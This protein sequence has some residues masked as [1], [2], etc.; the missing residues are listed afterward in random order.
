MYLSFEFVFLTGTLQKGKSMKSIIYLALTLISLLSMPLQ[1]YESKTNPK[2]E[3]HVI[4]KVLETVNAAGYTYLK[5]EGADKKQFW[6]A[7]QEAE[8]K[9]G[10][11]VQADTNNLMEN[12]QSKTLNRTFDKIYFAMD[13]KKGKT[14]ESLSTI[15]TKT[16]EYSPQGKKEAVAIK[17]IEKL[18]D[19]KSIEEIFSGKNELK[20]KIVKLRGQVVKYNS[21]IMGKNW[22][23]LQDGS[24]KTGENDLVITSDDEVSLGDIIEVQGKVILDKDFGAGY[25]YEVILEEG[26]VL[27]K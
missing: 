14:A 12:F 6:I 22:I 17:K 18:K 9:V 21:G 23:H 24:G 2:T 4:G 25:K 16:P 3:N 5:V 26:K 13:L 8:I 20:D 7:S 27:K 19:G 10:E 11:F 15:E 1:A